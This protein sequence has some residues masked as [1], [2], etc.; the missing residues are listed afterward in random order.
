LEALAAGTPVLLSPHVDLAA[1]AV[2]AGVGAV[3]PLEPAALRKDLVDL[4]SVANHTDQLREKARA[5]V[6]Q[7]YG[8]G[9]ITREL[10]QHYQRVVQGSRDREPVACPG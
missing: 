10:T 6:R 4:L 7:R 1:A 3:T 5:W 2:N 8:W 9:R